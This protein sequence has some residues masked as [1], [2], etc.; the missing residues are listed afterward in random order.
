MTPSF[1]PAV[2]GDAE[3]LSG[4]ALRSKALWGYDAAFMAACIE[5]LTVTPEL[6]SGGEVWV[7]DPHSAWGK[8]AG[9]YSLEIPDEPKTP[10]ELGLFFVEPAAKGTGLGRAMWAH[11]EGRL[12]TNKLIGVVLDSDP[13]A[14]GFYE[15]M[16]AII[17]GHSPSG[18]IAGRTLPR[19]EKRFSRPE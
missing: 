17:V 10:A 4:L 5:E 14:A 18:S 16:G 15:H 3:T 6:I 7:A 19:M 11:M 1:R 2:A 13:F 12:A 8:I 9:F